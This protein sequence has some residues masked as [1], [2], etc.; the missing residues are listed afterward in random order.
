MNWFK[1]LKMKREK[2][3]AKKL[4]EEKEKESEEAIKYYKS[5][6]FC[7]DS[8]E[9]DIQ[10]E[11]EGAEKEERFMA[12]MTRDFS[13]IKVGDWILAKFCL[14]KI[15]KFYVV[16]ITGIEPVLEAKFARRIRVSSYF[17]WP[18]VE[19][20]SII[21]HEE[22]VLNLPDPIYDKREKLKFDI[23]FDCYNIM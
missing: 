18:D 14:K 3:V 8:E 20:K 2:K 6:S 10:D 22:I 19:D 13:S 17:H 9:Y 16:Q 12:T 5:L 11:I 23:S 1:K 7:S 21:S 15:N 4:F